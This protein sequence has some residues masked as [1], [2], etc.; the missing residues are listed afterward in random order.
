MFGDFIYLEE[1]HDEDVKMRL[2]AKKKNLERLEN[3]LKTFQ[4]QVSMILQ[5]LSKHF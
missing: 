3:G 4:L 1:V 5:N 2:F